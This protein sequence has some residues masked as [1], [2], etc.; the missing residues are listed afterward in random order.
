MAEPLQPMVTDWSRA[1]AVMAHPDDVEFGAAGAVAAWTAAGKSVTYL[2]LTKGEAGIDGMSPDKAGEVRAGEQR[3]SAALVGVTDVEFLD[4][5][6]GVI[7]YGVPLRRDIA[8]A[9]RRCQPELIVIFNHHDTFPGGKRNSPDHRHTGQALLDAVG[10]AGNRWIFPDPDLE[11]WGGVRYVAVAQ[12]P[13]ATH[14]VDITDTLEVA[15][16]SIEVHASYL[17]GIGLRDVR[18]PFTAITK[19]MGERFGGVPAI[20]LE[21]LVR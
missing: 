6:D 14:A 15:I 21:V 9:I 17:D 13:Q 5:R 2:L 12:S 20:A 18:G 4:Y 1:L 16:A 11:P 8:I 10:D 7:E 19:G 3:A